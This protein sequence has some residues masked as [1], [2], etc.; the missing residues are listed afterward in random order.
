[1]VV[2]ILIFK[3]QPKWQHGITTTATIHLT[4]VDGVIALDIVALQYF[5]GALGDI[6]VPRI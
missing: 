6:Y 4:P 5:I 3:A 1:M 2:G